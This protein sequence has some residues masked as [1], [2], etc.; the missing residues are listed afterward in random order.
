LIRERCGFDMWISFRFR[1]YLLTRRKD[2]R[3]KRGPGVKA[4]RSEP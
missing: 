3:G 4:E 2:P 1:L